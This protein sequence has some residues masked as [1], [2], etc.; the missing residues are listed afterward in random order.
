MS[1]TISYG[2]KYD[3]TL[4]RAQVAQAFRRDVKSAIKSGA[5]PAGLKLS[6]TCPR[7]NSI[8]V[9]IQACPGVAFVNPH[10]DP[11]TAG[12]RFMANKYR[13]TDAG[14]A[15]RETLSRMLGAYNFD[16]SDSMTDYFHVNFYA[17]IDFDRDFEQ[18]ERVRAAIA[19]VGSDAAC[20]IEIALDCFAR[21]LLGLAGVR[22]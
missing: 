6:V 2:A 17:F 16:G 7:G 12:S 13:Y 4:T 10:Y 19:P 22:A 8:R 21:G 9:E 3:K 20:V 11:N 15:L 5:L 14:H 18:A 1:N